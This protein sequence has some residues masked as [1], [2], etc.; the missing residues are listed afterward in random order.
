MILESTAA[1]E[2]WFLRLGAL[3]GFISVA[4]GAFGA[5]ALADSLSPR[6]LEIFETAVRYQMF[7]AVA[8][9]VTAFLVPRRAGRSASAA[10]WAFA[11][12]TLIFSGSLYAL[13]LSG[14]GWLGAIT[15][16]GGVTW[17]I[18]WL[19]LFRAAGRPRVLHAEL[20]GHDVD[21]H[22]VSGG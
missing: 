20:E 6:S 8:L 7:H 12:G 15:P 19:L 22:D 11:F 10:G 13:A 16:I 5:H 4:A 1:N 3:S 2:R 18:G 17:L 14:V 21:L 9:L